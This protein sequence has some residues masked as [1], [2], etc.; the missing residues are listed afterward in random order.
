MTMNLALRCLV[1]SLVSYA[2]LFLARYMH[3]FILLMD[4]ESII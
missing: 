3:N 1:Y 4:N 2:L